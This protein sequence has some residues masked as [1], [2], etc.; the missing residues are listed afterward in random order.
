MANFRISR[1]T[2]VLRN[3]EKMKW[4]MKLYNIQFTIYNIHYYAT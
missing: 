2:K 1:A 4:K 3:M